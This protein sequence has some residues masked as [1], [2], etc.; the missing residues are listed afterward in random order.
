MAQERDVRKRSHSS[1]VGWTIWRWRREIITSLM[2]YVSSFPLERESTHD[3]MYT[4]IS[5]RW[6]SQSFKPSH[7][8]FDDVPI[9]PSV[10]NLIGF[11][12]CRSSIW[13]FPN[14]LGSPNRLI[15]SGGTLKKYS[16]SS[17]TI[18]SY[19]WLFSVVRQA[20]GYIRILVTVARFFPI[21][22]I[23]IFHRCVTAVVKPIDWEPLCL[24]GYA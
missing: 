19:L 4:I 13:K 6:L 1:C 22:V 12:S 7:V 21:F 11:W 9:D 8:S 3:D 18:I 10:S 2:S 24:H 16:P 14:S 15:P 23:F 20:T 5:L 17:I